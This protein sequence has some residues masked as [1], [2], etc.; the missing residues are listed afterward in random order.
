MATYG[1]DHRAPR[2]NLNLV[3]D[4]AQT[5]D[6]SLNQNQAEAHETE[7]QDEQ[8]P[9]VG[10]GARVEDE[11]HAGHENDPAHH[12]ASSI[13]ITRSV[14]SQRWVRSSLWL[15]GSQRKL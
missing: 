14:G 4:L 8:Q 5:L 1:E 13:T 3:L 7:P 15:T 12:A 2:M 9:V 6:L 11:P 10:V